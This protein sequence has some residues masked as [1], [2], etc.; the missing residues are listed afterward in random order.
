MNFDLVRVVRSIC[1]IEMEHFSIDSCMR[2]YQVYKG[3][4]EASSGE[5]LPY[6]GGS[7]EVLASLFRLILPLL[8]SIAPCDRGPCRSSALST[9]HKYYREL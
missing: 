8:S 2:D 4:W 3:V 7:G 1:M 9:G 6:R 5:E